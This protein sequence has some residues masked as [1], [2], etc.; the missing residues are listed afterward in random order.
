MF[1]LLNG[2]TPMQTPFLTGPKDKVQSCALS[3]PLLIPG[4]QR[5]DG[6]A[7]YIPNRKL[8]EMIVLPIYRKDNLGP[9]EMQTKTIAWQNKHDVVGIRRELKSYMDKIQSL[10]ERGKFP[11]TGF[12][13]ELC[14]PLG[15]EDFLIK[16]CVRCQCPYCEISS[17][18]GS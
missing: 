4:F 2:P 7:Y 8:L 9:R 11:K 12:L 6:S 13:F 3:R 17:C 18:R 16:T 15:D 1:A 14:N 10:I 5:L